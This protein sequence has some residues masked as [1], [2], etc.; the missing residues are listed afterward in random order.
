M[1][2][3]FFFF[4]AAMLLSI[5]IMINSASAATY[6]VSTSGSDSYP[7]TP[8]QPLRTIQH[9]ADIVNPG[10]TCL[11]Q[12]GTYDEPHVN[13]RRGGTMSNKVTFRATGRAVM[14]GFYIRSSSVVIDGFD[15]TRYKGIWDSHIGNT[16]VSGLRDLHVWNNTIHDGISMDLNDVYMYNINSTSGY[17][18]SANANFITAG[19]AVGDFFN[20]NCDYNPVTDSYGILNPFRIDS[21]TNNRLDVSLITSGGTAPYNKG[22]VRCRFLYNVYGI[23]ID[24]DGYSI[25]GNKM[26]NL[27][28]NFINLNG[29]NGVV[30][31][32]EI[33]YTNGWDIFRVFGSNYVIRN[34]YAHDSQIPW[35][36]GNH[37][38]LFQTWGTETLDTISKNVLIEH[39]FFINLSTAICQLNNEWSHNRSLVSAEIKNWT[40]NGNVIVGSSEVTQGSIG[41]PEIDWHDNTFYKV[42]GSG[43][44]GVVLGFSDVA[45]NSASYNNVFLGTGGDRI[46]SGWY[47]QGGTGFFADY[48]FVANSP[49]S[50]TKKSDVCPGDSQQFCEAHGINGGDPLML[51]TE[52]PLGADGLPWT[53]DD[54]LIPLSIS[55]L[56]SAGR[57]GKTIGA[58]ECQGCISSNPVA[59]FSIDKASGYEPL[60]INFDASKSLSCASSISSYQWNFGDGTTATGALTSHTFSSGTR[61]ITLT[62]TNNL[63]RQTTYQ[64]TITVY[65]SLIPNLVFYMNFDNNIL[66]WSGRNHYIS[67]FG[68]ISFAEGKSGLAMKNDELKQGYIE[69]RHSS[70]LDAMD[71]LS[72]SLWLKKNYPL[73]QEDFLMKFLSYQLTMYPQYIGVKLFN[74]SGGQ[75][76]LSSPNGIG[77]DT[78]WHHYAVVYNGTEFRLYIDKT[79]VARKP[80]QSSIYHAAD[81]RPLT[82]GKDPW[83]GYFNGSLDELRIYD[84]ALSDA[85]I[86]DL[87]DLRGTVQSTCSEKGG[88][89]CTTNEFCSSDFIQAPD[90]YRCCPLA[91]ITPTISSAGLV[92]HINFEDS[93]N[94]LVFSDKSGSGNDA[95]C[96]KDF[97]VNNDISDQHIFADQ[98]P[99]K[100][101]GP[102]GSQAAAFSG[103]VCNLSS[104][105]LGVGNSYMIGNLS[106]GSILFWAYYN[107]PSDPSYLVPH[108]SPQFQKILDGYTAGA[109]DSWLIARE[110]ASYTSLRIAD[111]SGLNRDPTAFP[112]LNMNGKWNHYAITWDGSNIKGYF[113][114][115]F[116]NQSS[117][118]GISKF[119]ISNYLAIGA[120]KH[121]SDGR[122]AFTNNCRTYY[123]EA[124]A[125]HGYSAS[126]EFVMPNAGFLNGRLD[127]IRIYNRSLQPVEVYAI[128]NFLDNI[129]TC[130]HRSD[131]NCNSCVDTPELNAFISKWYMSSTDVTLRELM[132]AIGWWKRGG[133]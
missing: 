26:Y 91:C 122:N 124:V 85:E 68:N 78:N 130:I 81:N 10:D 110:Y 1:R 83:G 49:P 87:Y 19:M 9:C 65:P 66:D 72:I 4:S 113:N 2:M 34:N 96:Q 129:T 95:T 6:Y 71:R 44:A 93:F 31:N 88:D 104:K 126:Q 102:D 107:P 76:S 64:K 103:S 20:A 132:E 108:T 39:N 100:T 7:G 63:G 23:S 22:P 41:I 13:I 25:S 33:Y 28:G 77:S 60:T 128:A 21:L 62:V 131:L 17:L 58:Y 8:A 12:A 70:D 133:C 112:D 116:F 125:Y 118:S 84:K 24:A 115:T 46:N 3:K 73:A 27:W 37:P 111:D 120:L 97:Y 74:Q 11:V 114:G 32:N 117:Q 69:A 121:N 106:K 119:S 38:D 99:G 35:G 67:L 16:G 82:I 36:I 56:C 47:S 80:M 86:S 50:F 51:N 30:E 18:I 94:G 57:D 5:I 98:C 40:L 101:I 43:G 52:S 92:L 75:Y 89:I 14:K 48:N 79:I 55:S 109:A 42:G 54:G 15:I 45:T 127:D 53:S 61:T 123:P 105:Y 59:F 90:S 29:N